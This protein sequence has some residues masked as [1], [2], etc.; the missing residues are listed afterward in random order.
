MFPHLGLLCYFAHAG[1][2]WQLVYDDQLQ[3]LAHSVELRCLFQI[4]SL[5]LQVH[6]GW[7]NQLASIEFF[8]VVSS[9]KV[10]WLFSQNGKQKL[11]LEMRRININKV[12][13]KQFLKRMFTSTNITITLKG[14][15][16]IDTYEST[17]KEQCTSQSNKYYLLTRS[18]FVEFFIGHSEML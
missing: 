8:L 2:L 4:G 17:M 13:Q 14:K 1:P 15:L 12:L 10:Q 7:Q 5:Q 16:T 11:Y 9:S 3:L 6:L 18:N